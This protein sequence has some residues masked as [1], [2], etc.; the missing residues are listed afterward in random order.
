MYFL[1][2]SNINVNPRSRPERGRPYGLDKKAYKSMR[3]T[4]G[5]LFTWLKAFRR[6]TIRYERLAST[7]LALIKYIHNNIPE[8]FAMSSIYGSVN[9][10]CNKHIQLTG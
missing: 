6:V 9:F 5:R 7:F 10:R 1:S 3:S 8:G 2:R 4:V